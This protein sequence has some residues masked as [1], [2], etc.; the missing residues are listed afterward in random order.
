M[1]DSPVIAA[2]CSDRDF[3]T[4]ECILTQIKTAINLQASVTI[5]TIYCLSSIRDNA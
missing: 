5:E 1:N 2:L 3:Y 4:N